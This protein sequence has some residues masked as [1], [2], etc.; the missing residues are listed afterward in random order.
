MTKHELVLAE[1][2]VLANDSKFGENEAQKCETRLR[3]Y[4]EL[5]NGFMEL[6]RLVS[7]EQFTRDKE[8][9][10]IATD[11][12]LFK[13]YGYQVGKVKHHQTFIHLK[14]RSK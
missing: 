8:N 3:D 11:H 6:V 13:L 12:F 5:T 7:L 9:I 2:C 1:I 10:S 14:S 4:L